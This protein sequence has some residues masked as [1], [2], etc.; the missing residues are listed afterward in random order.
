MPED[1]EY[2]VTA[3]KSERRRCPF[4][5]QETTWNFYERKLWMG[6]KKESYWACSRCGRRLSDLP[7]QTATA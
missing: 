4:C 1:G 5:K 3:V 2:R 6:L 7:A